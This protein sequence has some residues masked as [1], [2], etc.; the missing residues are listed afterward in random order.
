MTQTDG[1]GAVDAVRS[2]SGSC[3]VGRLLCR[4]F[5]AAL[6]A[7]DFE[8]PVAGSYIP[9]YEPRSSPLQ[10]RY[11]AHDYAPSESEGEDEVGGMLIASSRKGKGKRKQAAR[12]KGSGS[13][14][15]KKQKQM[16]HGKKS[17]RKSRK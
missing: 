6:D 12:K 11:D 4:R 15:A 10:A 14:S 7:T 2:W 16:G 9:E 17:K 5:L 3:K 13:C 8:L 1:S